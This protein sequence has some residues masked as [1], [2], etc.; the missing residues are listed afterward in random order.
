MTEYSSVHVSSDRLLTQR[1]KWYLLLGPESK[2]TNVISNPLWS[3]HKY[4]QNDNR[5][6]VIIE[7]DQITINPRRACS[8]CT[9]LLIT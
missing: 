3:V 1:D 5:L 2:V 7:P 4:M 6:E 9:I 8:F